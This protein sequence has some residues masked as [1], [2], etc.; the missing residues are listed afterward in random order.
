MS[1]KIDKFISQH[2][3]YFDRNRQFLELNDWHV[4]NVVPSEDDSDDDEVQEKSSKRRKAILKKEADLVGGILSRLKAFLKVAE[5]DRHKAN[6]I[7]FIQS[8]AETIE[9]FIHKC[10]FYI[11]DNPVDDIDNDLKRSYEISFQDDVFGHQISVYDTLHGM[12]L[13]AEIDGKDIVFY[14]NEK[15]SLVMKE[16]L[17]TKLPDVKHLTDNIQV[18]W[19]IISSN[20]MY[21]NML[22][23]RPQDIPQ[24]NHKKHYFE[25][26][27]VVLQF[28]AEEMNKIRNGLT[29]GGYWI[30]PWLY[31]HLNFFRTRI[32][33]PNGEQPNIQ[34]DLRD[35][36]FFF[37]ENLKK[38]VSEKYPAFYEKAMLIYGT[39]RFGKS[40]IMASLAHWRTLTVYNASGTIVGGS[41]SDL[42]ALTN[43]IKTSMDNIEPAFKLTTNTKNWE[44]GETFFGIKEDQSTHLNYSSIIVQNLDGGTTKKTQKTAGLDPSVSMYDEIGKYDFLKPYLAALPSFATPYG[45]KCITVL[46][47]T[48]GEADLSQDAMTVLGNPAGYDLLP[49]DW[50]LLEN[51]VDPEYITWKRR[52]FATFF[53][54]QM[55]YEKGFIKKPIP[56]SEHLD[57]DDKELKEVEIHLTDWKNNTE[58]LDKKIEDAKKEKGSKGKLLE[59]Q[60]K[61]QYPKDPEDCFMSAGVNPFSPVEAKAHKKKLQETGELGRK[62]FLTED[63]NGKIIELTADNKELAEFPY[64][65][66]FVDAPIVLYESIPDYEPSYG[67]YIVGLDDYKQDQ[68]DTDSVGSFTVYKRTMINDVWSCRVVATYNARP[69]KH[70]KFHRQGHMLMKAFNAVCFMENE[71]MGFKDFLDN[72]RVTETWLLEGVDFASELDLNYN[73]RRQYGWN[74]SPKNIAHMMGKLIRYANEEIKIEMEDGTTRTILGLERIPDTGILDEMINFKK[75]GNFDRLRS[76]GSAL[77]YAEFL[78]SQWHVPKAPRR[79]EDEEMAQKKHKQRKKQMYRKQS[80]RGFF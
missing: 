6:V 63:T 68:S 26:D 24:W 1:E 17:I 75:D 13:E 38:C 21:I 36:E 47:G 49:M 19:N 43:K 39:R 79:R 15:A 54:G 37:V 42:A 23:N 50:D 51:K 70:S 16:P 69:P 40:V 2:K 62:V 12:N 32:P 22:K 73:G 80:R 61:V 7:E 34:P 65:G 72:K 31:F 3:S 53:P 18:D 29:I 14:K 67:Q 66:G 20:E 77:M 11:E 76:F 52:K 44:N 78:D 28:W 9:I 71:D 55:A 58:Y 25:Q 35:N 74:P 48:G 64:P 56:L 30:H 59:Q 10:E 41:S 27:P 45:F 8:T 33:Q 4:K 57:I 5:G 46:A 60:R